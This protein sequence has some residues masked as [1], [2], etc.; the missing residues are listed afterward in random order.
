MYYLV[1]RTFM[2]EGKGENQL[3]CKTETSEMADPVSDGGFDN[4][5]IGLAEYAEGEADN[6]FKTY[7]LHYIKDHQKPKVIATLQKEKS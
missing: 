7:E 1:C 4:L 5:E 6:T 3:T 2:R